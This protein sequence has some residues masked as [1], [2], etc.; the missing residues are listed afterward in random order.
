MAHLILDLSEA[1]KEPLQRLMYLSGV[2]E[3][4]AAELEMEYRRLYFQLRLESRLD[5]A[6]DL[7]LHSHKKIMAFTRA[8]NESRGRLVRWGDRRS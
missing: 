1:P 6:E 4:V 2:R 3:R 8:E 5:E 7:R